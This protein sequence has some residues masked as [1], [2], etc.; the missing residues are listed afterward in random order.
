MLGRKRKAE[1]LTGLDYLVVMADQAV[2]R[3][4]PYAAE[5]RHMVTTAIMAALGD[6]PVVAAV[7]GIISVETIEAGEPVRA[8]DALLVAQQL[9]AAIGPRPI[10]FA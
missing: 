8:I 6:D 9:D 1:R 10:S 3:G 4:D 7:G 2:E 5:F